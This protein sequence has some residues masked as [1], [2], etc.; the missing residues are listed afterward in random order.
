M[1]R[2]QSWQKNVTTLWSR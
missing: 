1:Q 2:L